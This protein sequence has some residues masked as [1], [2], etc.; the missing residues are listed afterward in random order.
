[1]KYFKLYLISL[2][3][4]T[5]AFAYTDNDID[6]VDD[7][8]DQCLHTPF[9]LLVDENGC[10]FGKSNHGALTLKVG[11]DISFNN[12]SDSST[13]LNFFALYEYN[14]WD[15]S[16]SNS[17]YTTFD[18]TSGGSS[19]A[20]D[21]YLSTGYLIK[22]DKLDTKL[23]LGTKLATAD[24]GVGTGENDYF[25]SLNLNY[26]LGEKQDFFLYYGYTLSGDTETIDYEDFSTLSIG[27]GY[28][29]TDKWYSGISY[30]YTGTNIADGDSYKAISWFNSYAFTQEFFATINYAHSLDNFSYDQTISLK[31]GVYFE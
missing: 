4:I 16:L 31:L 9:D 2:L 13:N 30:D 20:G 1:M 17:N 18:N 12:P 19:E 25:A 10:A 26:F 27:T 8:I 22:N 7:S 23:S 29:I 24:E 6:G 21:L 15:I 28:T 14:N 5:S 11:S 3:S